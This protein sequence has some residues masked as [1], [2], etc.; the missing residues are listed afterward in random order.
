MARHAPMITPLRKR[1]MRSPMFT[2]T[3]ARPPLMRPHAILAKAP[4]SAAS[5]KAAPAVPR[6]SSGRSRAAPAVA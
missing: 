4:A 1:L 3:P 2:W 6:V 5:D